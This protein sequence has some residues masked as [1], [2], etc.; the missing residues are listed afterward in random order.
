MTANAISIIDHSILDSYRPLQGEGQPDIVTE[1][2]DVYL[3]DLPARMDRLRAAV[4][5]AKVQEVR[6]AA[7]AIKGSAGSVGAVLV[8]AL[9][10][11]LEENARAGTTDGADGLLGR[12]E[13]EVHRATAELK[14]LRQP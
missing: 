13:V 12:V 6:S 4:T 11:Q 3:E 10:A 5:A 9:C 8:A 2:I 1:F 14:K 7:H